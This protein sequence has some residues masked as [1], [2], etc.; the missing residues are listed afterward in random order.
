MRNVIFA[1]SII[2]SAML[3]S[4]CGVVT[5][6]YEPAYTSYGVVYDSPADWVDG[7][8]TYYPR[9]R[10]YNPQMYYGVDRVYYGSGIYNRGFYG[11]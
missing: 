1:L 7:G 8:Y 2:S 4:S 11:W 3:L 6:V 5:T 10:Y 9:Y